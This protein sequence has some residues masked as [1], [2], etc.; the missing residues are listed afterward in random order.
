MELEKDSLQV[1]VIESERIGKE[2]IRI[3]AFHRPAREYSGIKLQLCVIHLL[4]QLIIQGHLPEK[5]Q[6]RES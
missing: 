6:I 4:L 3:A 2:D 5:I 1:V